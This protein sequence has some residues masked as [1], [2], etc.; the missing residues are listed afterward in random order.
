M[1]RKS[2]NNNE[3]TLDQGDDEDI[4]GWSDRKIPIIGFEEELMQLSPGYNRRMYNY[5]GGNIMIAS[6]PS[7]PD[8]GTP[9]TSSAKSLHEL[10]MRHLA[11]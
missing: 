3:T 11:R 9:G 7:L 8:E 2:V 1:T 5:Q 10:G 4:G 6:H